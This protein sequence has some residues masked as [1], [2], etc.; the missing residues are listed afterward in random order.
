MLTG[1]LDKRRQLLQDLT[2]KFTRLATAE[3]HYFRRIVGA[4]NGRFLLGEAIVNEGG[5]DRRVAVVLLDTAFCSAEIK[6]EGLLKL[7][8]LPLRL[9]LAF[10][11]G[12]RD[13]ECLGVSRR[14]QALLPGRE[15]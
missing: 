12:A 2:S 14:L 1:L 5:I 8:P 11:D 9:P 15:Y 13:T 6:G 10:V 7:L 4:G 3:F